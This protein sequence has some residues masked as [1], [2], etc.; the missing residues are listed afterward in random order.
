MRRNF[1]TFAEFIDLFWN[2]VKHVAL[3]LCLM[4]LALTSD[5]FEAFY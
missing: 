1:G 5:G 4:R 2:E 3:Q